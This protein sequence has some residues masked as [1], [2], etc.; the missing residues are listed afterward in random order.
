MRRLIYIG[1]CMQLILLTGFI[2]TPKMEAAAKAADTGFIIEADR[3]EGEGMFIT[4]I[5]QETAAAESQPMLRITYQSAK[6]YGMKLTKRVDSPEG[7]VS[8]TMKADGPVFI[9]G[10]TV[11]TSAISFKGMCLQTNKVIPQI[12]LD[13]VVMVGHYMNAEES[14]LS[15]LKLETVYGGVGPEVP[16]M[17]QILH[18]VSALP[19]ATVGKEV[20]NVLQGKMPLVCG[21]EQKV[22]SL[23]D[24]VGNILNPDLV[25]GIT[26]PIVSITEPIVGIIR[27]VEE[28]VIGSILQ[29]VTEIIAPIEY[30]G[31]VVG[32]ITEPLGEVTGVVGKVTEPLGEVTGIVGKITEPLG[33]MSGVVEKV[34]K[35]LDG[36]TSAVG[37]VT[38]PLGK[39]S[40]PVT[41]P[42]VKGTKDVEKVVEPLQG[43]TSPVVDPLKE[44][45]KPVEEL[46]NL[47]LQQSESEETSEVSTETLCSRLN[48]E[49]GIMPEPFEMNSEQEKAFMELSP[50][51]EDKQ[52]DSSEKEN[53]LEGLLSIFRK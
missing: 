16:A 47:L 4:M 34:T 25:K 6:I 53:M 50:Q 3:V 22:P 40:K 11:D 51:A 39:V 43:V 32:K 8:I 35:P 48:Q 30:V 5:N 13:H 2:F 31:G 7:K 19:L 24:I 33:E 41:D 20:S 52:E 21:G 42:L 38:S 37:K 1:L 10:M 29:P 45:T 15:Q 23:E 17:T 27:P 44:V 28:E 49:M 14:E 9:N 26:K 46:L 12:G 36:V 18:D